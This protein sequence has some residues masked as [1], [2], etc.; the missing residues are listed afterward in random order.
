MSIDV[1]TYMECAL[2][3]IKEQIEETSSVMTEIFQAYPD[4]AFE[5]DLDKL[6]ELL[7]IASDSV[8]IFQNYDARYD[9]IA[10]RCWGDHPGGY[11]VQCRLCTVQRLCVDEETMCRQIGGRIFPA[12][13]Q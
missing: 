1:N 10:R 3:I 4:S 2:E 11:D 5:D 9:R 7:R 6:A 12:A 8:E 13:E